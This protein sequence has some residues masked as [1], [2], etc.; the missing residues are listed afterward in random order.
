M[1]FGR[2]HAVE[3]SNIRSD[4]GAVPADAMA[5]GDHRNKHR[6]RAFDNIGQKLVKK[7]ILR[8]F[9]GPR[10]R[11]CGPGVAFTTCTCR[12]IYRVHAQVGVRSSL[13]S[14]YHNEIHVVRPVRPVVRAQS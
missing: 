7:D 13:K 4:H 14:R 1:S 12:A 8:Q 10:N 2:A 3:H 6:K 5:A 9:P 11:S